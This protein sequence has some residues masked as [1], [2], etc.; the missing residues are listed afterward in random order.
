MYRSVFLFLSFIL[1]AVV[2]PVE[3]LTLAEALEQARAHH[4]THQALRA[5]TRAIEIE[6]HRTMRWE[7]PEWEMEVE[8]LGGEREYT[9]L[10]QQKIP[11]PR[12]VRSL[13]AA[14]QSRVEE[15]ERT[16]EIAEYE[17]DLAV[18][19]AFVEVLTQRELLHIRSDLVELAREAL[20][21]ASNKFAVAAVS[22]LD[23]IQ[24]GMSL[25]ALELDREETERALAASRST[26]ARWIG[27]D[28]PIMGKVVGNLFPSLDAALMLASSDTHPILAQR[29]ALLRQAEAGLALAGS[30]EW[31]GITIGAGARYEEEADANTG[32]LTVSWPLPVWNRNRAH[33]TE[34]A[35]R[36][37]AAEAELEAI[38]RDLEQQR[39]DAVTALDTAVERVEQYQNQLIPMAERAFAVSRDGYEAGRRSSLELLAAQQALAE[40]RIRHVEAQRDAREAAMI[41]RQFVQSEEE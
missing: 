34:A 16:A 40:I 18:E 6:A 17:I 36:V 35:W 27:V 11:W 23:V 3:A 19:A 28:L 29:Q 1:S 24:A 37:E 14:A 12:R 20:T 33:R 32:L 31:P 39:E 10:I 21:T 30:Q 7:N 4:P 25:L 38:Q 22:E 41:L 8:G 13:R 26:L 9:A 15:A 2:V 5:E